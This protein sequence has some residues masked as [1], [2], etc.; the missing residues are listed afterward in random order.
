MVKEKEKLQVIPAQHIHAGIFTVENLKTGTWKT[1]KIRTQRDREWSPGARMVSILKG[2]NNDPVTGNYIGIGF[3]NEDDKGA[4][5]FF[6]FNKYKGTPEAKQAEFFINMMEEAVP[7]PDIKMHSQT[8]CLR[9]GLAL[10]T[11]QSVTD[12]IGPECI[13][14]VRR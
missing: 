11:P 7:H 4:G 9:C 3:L 14:K 5:Y 8:F 6:P 2:R 10:T 13:K 1:F 12:G